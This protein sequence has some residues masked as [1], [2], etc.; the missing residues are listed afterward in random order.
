MDTSVM[1]LEE[2]AR[3]IH[4]SK[5]WV[6]HTLAKLGRPCVPVSKTFR[7]R[8]HWERVKEGEWRTK[9]ISEICKLVTDDQGNH[10]SIMVAN[11][12]RW[13]IKHQSP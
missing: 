12:Y 13:W 8:W 2:I 5:E 7:G 10:P 6:E 11:A 9:T 3:A 4:K 1:T